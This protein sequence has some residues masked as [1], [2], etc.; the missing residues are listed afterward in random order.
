M[1]NYTDIIAFVSI[2]MAITTL[3]NLWNWYKD[4]DNKDDLEYLDRIERK[5]LRVY[6]EMDDIRIKPGYSSYTQDKH[7]IYL[8]IRDPR[9]GEFYDEETMLHVGL[10]EL[11]HLISTS[12]DPE[13]VH[14]DEFMNNFGM[15]I[16][17]AEMMG[18]LTPGHD[19]QETYCETRDRV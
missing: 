7:T 8:C 11:A 1:S 18:L 4:L 16:G 19:V 17:R 9:T 3:Y 15:L 10:H 14:N 12:Y 6:P 2:I 13:N 5:M